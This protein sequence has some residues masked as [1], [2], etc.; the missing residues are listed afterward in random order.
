MATLLD[1]AVPFPNTFS[2]S[3]TINIK[4]N[5]YRLKEKV[6]AGLERSMSRKA[7]PPDNAAC[8]GFFGRLKNEM[9]YDRSWAGVEIDEFMEILNSY[10][11]WHNEKRIKLSLD[12]RSPL[13]YR[14]CLGLAA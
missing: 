9:F 7:C 3:T 8:E 13:E 2:D 12:G 1:S 10:L 11:I 5:S 4:G 6:K 14:L